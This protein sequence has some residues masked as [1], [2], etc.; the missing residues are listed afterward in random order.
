VGTDTKNPKIATNRL[1]EQS[2]KYFAALK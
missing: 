1:H 2:V